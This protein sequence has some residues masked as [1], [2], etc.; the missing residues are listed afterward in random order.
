MAHH[1]AWRHRLH[2]VIFEADTPAGRAF[3][4]ALFIAI[5][6][7]VAIV[8]LNSVAS[9][10]ERFGQALYVTEWVFTIF[11]TIEY[12]LRLISIGRPWR[13][14]FSFF[15]IVDLLAIIPTYLDVLVPGSHQLLVIRILRLLRIF[16][17][18]KLV[19][20]VSEANLL[21]ASLRA[22]R[23]KMAV[24]FTTVST[25]VV[26]FGS[27]MYVVE[28]DNPGYTSIPKAIYWAV[29]TITTVGYGQITP[30]TPLGQA[31]SAMVMIL[32][33][34]IIAIPTGIIT[35]ELAQRHRNRTN[36]Q[37]CEECGADGHD[38]DAKFCRRCGSVINAM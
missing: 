5:I 23:P 38:D 7:S 9:V 17:V 21:L 10:H 20:F 22:A 27:L 30:E 36:T 1:S 4:L 2:E 34:S 35:A 32:G 37:V 28:P 14:V 11:F 13:Y 16:R 18:L 12:V 3:D 25:L 33:Y 24:F 26:I 31:I 15:G 19:Q 8:M 29:V 6:V